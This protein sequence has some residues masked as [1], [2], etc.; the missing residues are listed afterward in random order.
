[1]VQQKLTL[2]IM[3]RKYPVRCSADESD[4]L[5]QAARLLQQRIHDKQQAGKYLNNE[6]LA[7]MVAL[8]AVYDQLSTQ[9]ELHQRD[10]QVL[11]LLH[12]IDSA[13]MQDAEGLLQQV[14][15]DT[16]TGGK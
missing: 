12:K 10:Q 11:R 15:N 13:G 16:E 2:T 8:D 5:Q 3:N 9:Q 14:P 7:V 1:M 4:L 6:Q